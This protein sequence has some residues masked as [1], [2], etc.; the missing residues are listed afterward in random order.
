MTAEQKKSFLKI[1]SVL[2]LTLIC[3]ALITGLSYRFDNKYTLNSLQPISGMLCLTE[4]DLAAKPLYFLTEGWEVYPDKLFTPENFTA[5]SAN[6]FMQTASIGHYNDFSFGQSN[7]DGSGCASYHLTLFLPDAL[8]TYSLAL[9]EIFSSYRLYIDDK[10]ALTMG[11]PDSGQYSPAIGERTVTFSASGTVEILLSVSNYSHYYS[12]LTYPPMFGEPAAV[13]RVQEIRLFSR[14]LVTAVIFLIA[15]AALYSLKHGQA[16]HR[17]TFLYFLTCLCLWGYTAYPVITS[18]F[19]LTTRFWYTLELLCIYGMYLLVIL[20]QNQIRHISVKKNLLVCVPAGLFCVFAAGYALF[21]GNSYVLNHTFE[22]LAHIVKLF[23]AVYLLVSAL[24]AA[25]HEEDKSLLFLSGTVGFA[26]S[27]IADRVLPCYEPVYGGWFTEYGGIYLTLC[28]GIIILSVLADTYSLQLTLAEEKRQLARQVAMQKLHYQELTEKIEDSIRHRHDE[29]HHLKMIC[30]LLENNELDK[31]KDY[32]MDFRFSSS[33]QE[34]TVL[35]LNMA[36][37]AMLQFYR[38]QC[39]ENHIDFSANADIPADIRISDMTI[40]IIFG[41]LLENAFDACM[42]VPECDRYICVSARY[43]NGSLLI[44]IENSAAE[45]P[46]LK[47]GRFLSSKHSGF[48][49]GSQSVKAA[50]GYYN[51]QLKYDY[52]KTSFRVSLILTEPQ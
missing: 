42:Q 48:G 51:G 50:A 23:T 4:K 38:H 7:R 45:E 33:T 2:V 21:P 3:S 31:L 34:R 41:N 44:R 16:S 12:G 5:E 35:C 20:L 46:R 1:I 24:Y 8:Q 11:N 29:R 37:D 43:R 19:T 26:F 32:L 17:I 25:W 15:L 30:M 14:A 47:N 22:F 40:S 49:V 9:P 10:Q 28:L 18:F 39:T 13:S 6:A 36:A 27:L 52:T